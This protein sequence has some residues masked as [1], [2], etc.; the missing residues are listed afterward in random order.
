MSSKNGLCLKKRYSYRFVL[1]IISLM[2]SAASPVIA[3]DEE[4]VFT[5]EEITVTAEKREMV[6]K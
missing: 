2:L 3:Q 5:L 4:D 1:F 6:G